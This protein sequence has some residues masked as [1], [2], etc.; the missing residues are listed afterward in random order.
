M[1]KRGD[2]RVSKPRGPRS[3]SHGQKLN[4]EQRAFIVT[5]LAVYESPGDVLQQLAERFGVDVSH[6]AVSS[7]SPENS[8][9][10]A[11]RWIDLFHTTRRAFLA[12][13][14]AEPIAHQAY[15]IRELGRVYKAAM[16][17]GDFAPANK[18]L[19]TAA[20]E[21]GGLLTNTRNVTG[22]VE[23]THVVT[24]DEQR[25]MLH[26]RLAEALAKRKAAKAQPQPT[27]KH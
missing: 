24:E 19:E 17:A 27:T 23:H 1:A 26:D 5:K 6:Q 8:R 12:E 3:S 11:K 10:L 18:A 15:R 21:M 14:A 20:K 22:K 13:V 2:S 16:D 25:N 9:K 7:Y 4:D